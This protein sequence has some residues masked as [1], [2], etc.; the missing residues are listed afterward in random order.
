M[1]VFR[2]VLTNIWYLCRPFRTESQPD[3]ALSGGWAGS[4]SSKYFACGNPGRPLEADT[5]SM[6]PGSRP[7]AAHTTQLCRDAAD[8]EPTTPC[9][10]EAPTRQRFPLGPDST[11]AAALPMPSS[12]IVRDQHVNQLEAC[13]VKQVRHCTVRLVDASKQCEHGLPS[14]CNKEKV[15]AVPNATLPCD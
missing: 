2:Q 7:L 4:N 9:C 13:V 15:K 8:L 3:S 6:N 1:V 12:T 5:P 14:V 11:A 10:P